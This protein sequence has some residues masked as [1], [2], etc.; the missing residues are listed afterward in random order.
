MFKNYL[1]IAVRNLIKHKLFSFINI[2]GLALGI[3]S[4]I[5]II[6]F[7]KYEHSYD[8]YHENADRPYRLTV[9]AMM[10]NTKINSMYSSAITFSKLLSDFPEVEVGVK[11]LKIKTTSVLLGN[12]RFYGSKI[13]HTES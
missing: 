3:T 10:G 6:L 5:L 7:V 12:R 11:L 4:C 2:L 13:L 8:K 1:K 9:K